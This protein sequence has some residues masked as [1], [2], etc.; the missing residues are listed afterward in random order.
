MPAGGCC[1]CACRM[2]KMPAQS[3]VTIIAMYEKFNCIP[4][5]K[6]YPTFCR[7]ASTW[8]TGCWVILIGEEHTLGEHDMRYG[9]TVLVSWIW[10][11]SLGSSFKQCCSVLLLPSLHPVSIDVERTGIYQTSYKSV[12]VGISSNA[13]QSDGFRSP[14]HS[15]KRK[16]TPDAVN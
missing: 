1:C 13:S 8:S 11:G 4:D 7:A 3:I 9:N 14:S 6:I 16:A 12:I 10:S 2:I 15:L 5:N